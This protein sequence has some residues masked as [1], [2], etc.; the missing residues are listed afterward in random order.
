MSA[1]YKVSVILDEEGLNEQLLSFPISLINNMK[2]RSGYPSLDPY[3]SQKFLVANIQE[4]F[5]EVFGIPYTP[6]NYGNIKSQFISASDIVIAFKMTHSEEF[7]MN[8]VNRIMSKVSDGAAVLILKDVKAPEFSYNLLALPHMYP[9]CLIEFG[10]F[11]S[12]E[13]MNEIAE[14]FYSKAASFVHLRS[15]K[16][17]VTAPEPGIFS[18]TK[19]KSGDEIFASISN[20]D[21]L[22]TS[23]KERWLKNPDL[24]DDSLKKA[25]LYTKS[26]LKM[27]GYSFGADV[28]RSGEI[29][30]QTAMIGYNECL[31]D[32]SFRSQIV[33][34]SSAILGQYGVPARTRDRHGLLERFESEDIHIAGLVVTDYSFNYNHFQAFQSLSGWLKQY[35]VPAIYG[36]EVDTRALILDLR[37]HGSSLG[38]LVQDFHDPEKIPFED[39][40]LRNLVS[41]VSVKKPVYFE[42]GPLRVILMDF[43]VKNNIL[44]CLLDAGVSLLVVPWNHELGKEQYDGILLSNGPGDPAMMKE[45]IKTL[46]NELKKENPVPIMGVCMGNQLLGHAAGANTYKMT[47]GNRGHNQPVVDLTTGKTYITSQN[48]GYAINSKLLPADWAQY[49]INLN[50]HTNE[51]IRHLMKPFFSVQFHPEANGGPWDTRFLFD[52]FIHNIVARKYLTIKKPLLRL[53]ENEQYVERLPGKDHLKFDENGNYHLIS[54]Y[55]F[56][57]KRKHKN[58]RK[59]LVIGS[60]PLQI[61]QAGEFDY[62]GCQA[63]NVLREEGIQ[64]VLVN[65]NIATV[66][67]RVRG[68]ADVVYLSPLT[69]ESLTEIICKERP[70]GVFLSFGGQTALNLGV[71]LQEQGV[72]KKYGVQV[73]GTPIKSIQITED[74]EL[75]NEKLLEINEPIAKG[76]AACNMDEALNVARNV[77]G[78]PVI[79]RA[80]FALGGLGSGFAENDKE[81]TELCRVAF[82]TSP[83]VLIEKDL[84]GFK[85]LEYEV[86]RDM[87]DNCF[88]PAALENINPMGI[89]TGESIVVCP[90]QTINDEEHFRIRNKAIKIIKH[91]GVVGECNI[92]FAM[93]PN[94]S[95]EVYVIEVNARLSRSSALASKAT[96]YPLA[97]IAGKLMLGYP[98]AKVI[99]N[100]TKITSANFEPSLDYVVIKIPRWDMVKFSGV[101]RKIGS[102]MKSVGEVMAIGRTFEEALQKGLRMIDP[103]QVGFHYSTETGSYHEF[104]DIK[105]IEEELKKATDRQI[106]C[107]Y[108]ALK[109]GVPVKRIWELSK[110][111]MWFLSKLS[112]IVDIED[113]IQHFGSLEKVP[114]AVLKDAKHAGFS[115][116][117]IAKLL[118]IHEIEVRKHRK[119]LGIIP[120][121]KKIDTLAGEFPCETNNLYITY[122]AHS[123]EIDFSKTKRGIIILGGGCYRIGSSVEFDWCTVEFIKQLQA[124]GA[125]T[126]M[127]NNNPETVSTDHTM[128]D[129]LYFEELC[130]ETVMDIYEK[131]NPLGVTVSYGGQLPQNIAI[132]LEKAGAKILGHSSDSID[133][134]ENRVKFSNLLHELKIDQPE[135]AE[136]TSLESGISFAKKVGYPV[137]CRP[138]YVLSGAAMRLVNNENELKVMLVSST[139]VSPEHPIVISKFQED[140]M[141]VEFDGVAQDGE[142]ITYAISHHV[143]NA[144]VHSG[145]ATLVFPATHLSFEAS[146]KVKDITAELSKALK[147]NGPFNCQYLYKNDEFKVIE[148]NLRASRS[149]PFVCKILGINFMRPCAKLTLGLKNEPI[150]CNPKILGITHVGVKAPKFSFK[151]LLGSDPLLGLEM[152][153]TGEVGTIGVNK[154]VAFLKSY[155]STGDFKIPPRGSNVLIS[156][157]YDHELKKFM[158]NK[159]LEELN[160]MYK[161]YIFT[162]FTED[163]PNIRRLEFQEA[164]DL[165]MKRHFSLFLSF[166]RPLGAVF[167][168]DHFAKI[169]KLAVQF[170]VPAFLNEKLAEWF[171][172][173]M[174]K[175]ADK[176]IKY[177][178]SL[179]DYLGIKSEDPNENWQ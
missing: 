74:R 62:S 150:E 93:N 47:Y 129:R 73:L 144:G 142:I 9:N 135:W 22:G 161:V 156:A 19:A 88:T 148:L 136:L 177:D 26:G 58:V 127:I 49:F 110:I 52:I 35:N 168:D 107:I 51:G 61:G 66:Q 178:K 101:S 173:A 53:A 60:G 176:S 27:Q 12:L 165:I 50:D 34:C 45:A 120:Y 96:C 154:Y 117:Q 170:M 86:V 69:V 166:T 130:F 146:K 18:P 80:A 25:T 1:C 97:Y 118:K 8:I 131:E 147:I 68:L 91:L 20:V 14:G 57:M 128:S 43:G 99:N 138:S 4:K 87:F 143:E 137:I 23:Y 141:E 54:P 31:S 94:D 158:S 111:D 167:V 32:P 112:K 78:Y 37:Q 151:R 48:H 7:G 160:K 104:F 65:P 70:D 100:V 125:S 28:S 56:E 85:E 172:D 171:T 11:G 155:Q 17:G 153:S 63:I 140:S 115:D 81:L 116:R 39:P 44:R 95:R 5:E 15:P 13:E 105:N 3:I 114:K 121:V 119:N 82:V 89:H 157:D 149:F 83:Q 36:W 162:N 102:M 124:L 133:R 55:T 113:V 98:L 29:V 42:N 90:L 175:N 75:F 103:N 163:L 33:V 152:A 108:Q 2:I 64:S 21:I 71:Q 169:R 126:V 76:M 174:A 84:R 109:Q 159:H 24:K 59:V 40:N 122:N 38:K 72:F 106:Y 67:T 10:E 46:K 164:E 132:K 123:D 6:Y 145:D 41:E 30:F 179:Q 77:I 134:A 79:V 92:Q 16:M 139:D